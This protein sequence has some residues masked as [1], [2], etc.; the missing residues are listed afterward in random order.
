MLSASTKE[1]FCHTLTCLHNSIT[2]PKALCAISSTLLQCSR[3]FQPERKRSTLLKIRGGLSASVAFSQRM[4]KQQAYYF[5][6]CSFS[7]RWCVL[8][9]EAADAAAIQSMHS[10]HNSSAGTIATQSN[11]LLWEPFSNSL[12]RKSVSNPSDIKRE[13]DITIHNT[14]D[15]TQHNNCLG[16]F[17][18]TS[19][20]YL[21]CIKSLVKKGQI[22]FQ[23]RIHI[24]RIGPSKLLERRLTTM[25]CNPCSSCA[26]RVVASDD[27]Q[28]L[29]LKEERAARYIILDSRSGAHAV[30][31]APHRP[32]I[33]CS[34]VGTGAA[35]RAVRGL[36]F[37]FVDVQWVARLPK[38]ESLAFIQ[39]EF[40]YSTRPQKHKNAHVFQ[41]IAQRTIITSFL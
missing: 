11:H 25:V 20:I 33:L 35:A 27:L 12:N 22:H 13:T 7:S 1:I 8:V 4:K 18:I 3:R 2:F 29:A 31:S 5:S 32:R 26:L 19:Y 14:I 38:D 15:Y 6:L 30:S 10:R 28:A 9:V 37:E 24:L 16:L 39:L 34:E 21:D 23:L 36:A 41:N 40:C 17:T